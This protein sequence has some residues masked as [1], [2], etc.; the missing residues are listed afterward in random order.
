V[1]LLALAVILLV[2]VVTLLVG[3]GVLAL[4]VYRPSLCGPLAGAVAAMAL[5]VTVTALLVATTRG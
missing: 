4:L 1:T 3:V 5:M 2:V